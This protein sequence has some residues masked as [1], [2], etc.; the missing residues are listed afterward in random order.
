MVR[1]QL[2]AR[3]RTTAGIMAIVAASVSAPAFAAA[4]K[5]ALLSASDQA[6]AGQ[7]GT[8]QGDAQA[9]PEIIVTASK[10][11]ERLIDVPQ[12]VSVLSGEALVESGSL[13]FR[14]YASSIPSLNFSTAGAGATQITLRGVTVGFDVGS[15]VGIYVDEVPY[16]SSTAFTQNG[17][18]AFDAAL[19]DVDNVEVLR[20]PQGTLYGASAMGGLIR[21]ITKRP[22]AG[23]FGGELRA[24]V[25]E[26]RHGGISYNIGAV[27]N[28]PLV[29][30]KLAVRASGFQTHDGGYIDNVALG[31]KD[32]N[33]SDTYGG[34]LDLLL[35]PADGL[36]IRI[37]GF[38]QNI[39]RGGEGTVDY[40][41]S[42]GRSY[43]DLHQYRPFSEP[44]EQRYRI[45]SATVGYDMPWATLT[46]ISS[47]QTVR[48]DA[49]TDISAAYAP[50]LN[51]FGF[52]PYS[53][54]SYSQAFST[55]KFTQE[56]RLSSTTSSRPF[57]W[58]IGGFYT[59]EKSANDQFFK[60]LDIGGAPAPNT[61]YNLSA[62]SKY[63]EYAAFGNLTWHITDKF[64]V[65][66]GLRYARNNQL[67]TQ[68]GSGFLIGS[69]PPNRSHEGVVTYL[70]NARYRFS[71]HATA[72]LRYATGY[73][74][75]G[76]NIVLPGGNPTFEADRL[77]SYEA[78]F[79]AET[80]DRRFGID[81]SGYYIDWN[82]IQLQSI[83]QGFA[84][85]VNSDSGAAIKGAELTLN[86]RPADGLKLTTSLAYTDA[87]M[88]K[89]DPVLGA[90]K[91]E[92]LPGS[93]RFTASASADYQL[94]V[95]ESVSPSIGVT[96]RH[97]GNRMISFDNSPGY[98]QYRLPSYQT[99]DLRA[100]LSV[101]AFH[102]NPVE[103]QFY[104]RN[105]LDKRGQ[106][107][108]L[109]PEFGNRVAIVQPRTFGLS[110]STRF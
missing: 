63:E 42:G 33:R 35:L 87:Y 56:L 13:Q 11:E 93:A 5:E 43:G 49:V 24:G 8:A 57:E 85:Y 105:L 102:R 21:Y 58:I 30:D 98:P 80:A 71:D 7:A 82:N 110:L 14:D 3:L 70:A 44:F 37:T 36:S 4:E 97:V 86:A 61:L 50:L 2:R 12:S 75:G 89:A 76:P 27:A 107:S 90:A 62:P 106:L 46:S 88:S 72:Y 59:H 6:G 40:D 16:G 54:V 32:V 20:G 23:E 92:R 18:S 109:R 25:S 17:Q 64:D 91:G 22:D 74:P 79:K 38:L 77:K 83:V 99:F 1:E 41:Y 100:G 29:Q 47:Y 53:G 26:T 69:A 67:Y 73:R 45:V 10:R 34:R 78:G 31:K 81:V 94:P 52:G 39:S 103:V 96:F 101:D 19:F 108:V 95:A 55:D 60:L 84:V 65:T 28:V 48:T 15:T 104:V 9:E 51:A 66:G 68:F